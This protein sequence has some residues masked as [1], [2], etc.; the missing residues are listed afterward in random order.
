MA[1]ERLVLATDFPDPLVYLLDAAGQLAGPLRPG[2]RP[3]VEGQRVVLY[4][5]EGVWELDPATLATRPLL[6]L[7]ASG[8]REGQALPLADGRLLVA[9]RG[10]RRGE[11]LLAA[12]DGSLLW[13]RSTAP[14]GGRLPELRLAGDQV[15]VLGADGGVWALDL[16]EAALRPLFAAR[17]ELAPRDKPAAVAAGD[18]L[19]LN[20]RAGYVM[21]FQ[22]ERVE[23]AAADP[24]GTSP[25]RP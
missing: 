21:S 9:H 5:P 25:A 23:A 16:E 19:L 12:A 2:G 13:R 17:D 7:E 1:G 15:Y 14:L 11:L 4:R 3:S 6:A 18:T 8:L 10:P 20:T 24:E 22:G